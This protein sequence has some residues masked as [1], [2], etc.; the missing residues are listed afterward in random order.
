MGIEIAPLFG[1]CTW[2]CGITLCLECWADCGLAGVLPCDWRTVGSASWRHMHLPG[3]RR[4]FYHFPKQR[5]YPE[6]PRPAVILI[7]D[8]TYCDGKDR[9]I[10]E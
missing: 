8:P 6:N 7:I 9:K 10:G 5:K 4:L 3:E 2:P 1:R